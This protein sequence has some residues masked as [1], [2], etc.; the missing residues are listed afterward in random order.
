MKN[1]RHDVG[2]LCPQTNNK[3]KMSSPLSPCCSNFLNGP[4]V[5]TM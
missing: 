1:V 4:S 5:L 3:G 2:I